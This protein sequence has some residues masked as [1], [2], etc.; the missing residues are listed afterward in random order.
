MIRPYGTAGRPAV[1]LKFRNFWLFSQMAYVLPDLSLTGRTH[2]RRSPKYLGFP[3]VS[4]KLVS[5]RVDHD[6]LP[7]CMFLL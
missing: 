5:S 1:S 4:G 6:Q 7:S 3:E 2:V